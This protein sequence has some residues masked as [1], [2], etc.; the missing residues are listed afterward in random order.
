MD[1]LHLLEKNSATLKDNEC[2]PTSVNL[3][4]VIAHSTSGTQATEEENNAR[5]PAEAARRQT[6]FH[7]RIHGADEP[8]DRLD[9][10]N[11]CVHVD[12]SDS[13][14]DRLLDHREGLAV[15]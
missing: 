11:A 14:R 8:D 2:P 6:G 7:S 9:H 13:I 5:I 3:P 12:R 15:F 4:A 1:S 10:R